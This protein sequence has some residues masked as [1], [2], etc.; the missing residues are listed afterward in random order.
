[1]TFV[2]NNQN[3][4]RYLKATKFNTQFPMN[5]AICPQHINI[6]KMSKLKSNCKINFDTAIYFDNL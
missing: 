6:N 3:I 1:M 2:E 5:I 4:I